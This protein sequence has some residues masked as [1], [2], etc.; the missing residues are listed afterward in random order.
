MGESV[1]RLAD[2]EAFVAVVEHGSLTAAARAM[3]RSLQAVSRSLAA[4]ERDL[5]VELVRRTTRRS[6]PSAPGLAYYRRVRAA[7]SDLDDARREAAEGH[8]EA[9]GV[10]RVGASS[11]FGPGQVVPALAAFLERHPRLEA[12]LQINDRFVDLIAA[13]LDVAIRIGSLSDSTLRARRIAALR[14]V[15]FAAPGYLARAGRPERPDDLARHACLVWTGYRRGASWPFRVEGKDERVQV[16]GRLRT[17]SLTAAIEGA[18]RGLGI[19]AATLWQVRA[20]LDRGALEL[21]L[22]D[23]EPPPVPVH[24]LWPASRTPP[25]RTRLFVEFL[26]ERFRAEPP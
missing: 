13:G 22:T 14:Q 17:T 9:T 6:S 16:G 25:A 12:D 8:T 21:V 4:L 26:A 24:A 11:L 19:G 1:G 20:H 3:G 23:F 2:L 18:A 7:L 15:Y 10:L 5:G